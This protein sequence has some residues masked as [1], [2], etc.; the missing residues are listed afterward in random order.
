M[1]AVQK[2]EGH[3]GALPA[4][5]VEAHDPGLTVLEAAARVGVADPAEQVA[6][7]R[8]AQ[9]PVDGVVPLASVPTQ[10]SGR[11]RMMRRF[12]FLRSRASASSS[13]A[14][15]ATISRK[16]PARCSAAARSRRPSTAMIPP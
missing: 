13:K 11:N 6:V 10:I 3:R 9:E 12:F 15:A 4:F 8:E 2:S 16:K 1:A 7:V 5:I 14:G